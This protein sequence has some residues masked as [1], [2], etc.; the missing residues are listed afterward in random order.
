MGHATKC[1]DLIG[2]ILRILG[3]ICGSVITVGLG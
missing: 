1:A 2:D 3:P